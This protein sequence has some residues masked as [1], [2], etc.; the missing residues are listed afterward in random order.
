MEV[1]VFTDLDGTLLDHADYAWDA[2]WPALQRLKQLK[3]PLVLASSKTAAEIIPLHQQLDLAP[4]PAIVEN[5]AGIY[6]PDAGIDTTPSD[7]QRLR[8]RLSKIDPGLRAHF[9]GFGD[10][11][12]FEIAAATGLS[13]QQAVRAGNRQFTEPGVWAGSESALAGF[14]ENLDAQGIKARFGGRFLTLSFGRT[15]AMAM[16]EV[17]KDLKADITIALGDAPNDREMLEAAT[18][19]VIVRNTKAKPLP[20]LRGEQAGQIRRTAEE[21]PKGWN[22]A[23]SRLLGELG[24]DREQD[25]HG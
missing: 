17:L 3:I 19:G 25:T 20:Q 2:A 22:T 6:R 4:A 16:A 15:K 11:T 9:T 5:G 10:M 12:P 23:V 24:L 18:Y 13:L 7:Y 21:G 1:V 8:E 14:I